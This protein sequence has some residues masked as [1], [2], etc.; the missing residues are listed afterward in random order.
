MS[1]AEKF[2]VGAVAENLQREKKALFAVMTQRLKLAEEREAEEQK[3]LQV[4][5]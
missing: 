2:A 4:S 1:R 3:K 5:E